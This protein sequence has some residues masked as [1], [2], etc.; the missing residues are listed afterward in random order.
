[1]LVEYRYLYNF[2]FNLLASGFEESEK[3]TPIVV[4][5][6]RTYLVVII[7]ELTAYE[8]YAIEVNIKKR[9]NYNN[10]KVRGIRYRKFTSIYY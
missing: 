3:G 5:A 8:V 4:V 10:K 6:T 2:L 1:M 7:E 9:R